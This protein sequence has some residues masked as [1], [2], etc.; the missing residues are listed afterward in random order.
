[1]LKDFG[2][3]AVKL[4]RNPLGVLSLSFVL[5]YGIA[6]VVCTSSVLQ[7]GERLVLVWFV[8]LFPMVI[9]AAFY[10]LVTKH[11]SKLFGPSD[12]SDEA[13]FLAYT[14]GEIS[15][16]QA[17]SPR[18][19]PSLRTR[20]EYK[21]LNTLWT[22][23]VNLAPEYA[24]LWTFRINYGTPEFFEYRIASSKLI[25]EGL[26]GETD[27]G[28]IHLTVDGYAYCKKHYPEFPPEQWWPESKIDQHKLQ[29]ALGK[30]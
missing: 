26:V 28:Q 17:K 30:G 10:R 12:F 11:A 5:V 3:I 24:K 6:G 4:S 16:E 13:N 29:L 9:L 15:P 7:Q 20:M 25:G 19:E 23:Q 27:N 1:M 18:G 21:I 14:S 8:V 2:D 22:K